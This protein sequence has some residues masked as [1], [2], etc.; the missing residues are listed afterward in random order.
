MPTA[1]SRRP[2]RAWVASCQ[3]YSPTATGA[4]IMSA[5]RTASRSGA[6]IPPRSAMSTD[7]AT[8]SAPSAATPMTIGVSA[9]PV[10][11]RAAADSR[12]GAAID[13][14]RS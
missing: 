6:G 2:N 11:R 8:S 9:G 13:A 5:L 10:R 1:T 4:P 3:A 12:M 7:A 14:S